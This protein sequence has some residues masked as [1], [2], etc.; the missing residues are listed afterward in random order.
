V[1]AAA[2]SRRRGSAAVANEKE[3]DRGNLLNHT[4]GNEKKKSRYTFIYTMKKEE[5]RGNSLKHKQAIEKEG[6]A[7]HS[8]IHIEKGQILYAKVVVRA[9]SRQRGA[10]SA[11][12][13]QAAARGAG[14]AR[15]LAHS[16]R[17]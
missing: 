7:I 5:D 16:Q 6:P 8:Y 11:R 4:S 9:R 14:S 2:L 12:A 10:G 15:G 1:R 13:E 17:A 3:E